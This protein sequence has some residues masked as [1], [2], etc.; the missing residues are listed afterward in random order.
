M[1]L[2]ISSEYVFLHRY[3]GVVVRK[4]LHLCMYRWGPAATKRFDPLQV[5][6]A[7]LT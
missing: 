1:A 2:E 6:S 3:R 7:G 5:A 4:G